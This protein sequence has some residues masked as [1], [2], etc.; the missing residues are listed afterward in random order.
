MTGKLYATGLGFTIDNE[1]PWTP[2]RYNN[3]LDTDKVTDEQV[4]DKYIRLWAISFLGNWYVEKHKNDLTD[5]HAD[6]QLF[7]VACG[8]TGTY[9]ERTTGR[10]VR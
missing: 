6:F 9:S 7:T 2:E 10:S 8:C 5:R 3:L 4:F 1:H